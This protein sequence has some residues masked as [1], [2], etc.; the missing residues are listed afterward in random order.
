MGRKMK[1]LSQDLDMFLVNT[2]P[3]PIQITLKL[4]CTPL[5]FPLF[6]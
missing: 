3:D 5:Q 1:L 4:I 2:D 6:Q